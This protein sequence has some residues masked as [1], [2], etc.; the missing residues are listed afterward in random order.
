MAVVTNEVGSGIVPANPLSR[1]FRDL[2]GLINRNVS[3]ASDEAYLV[4]S[5]RALKLE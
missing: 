1:E 3:L 4:V 2:A 5:G